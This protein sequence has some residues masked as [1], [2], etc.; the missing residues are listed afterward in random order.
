MADMELYQCIL[1][2]KSACVIKDKEAIL[3][4]RKEKK[5]AWCKLLKN[6][7]KWKLTSESLNVPNMLSV[8]KFRYFRLFFVN[9]IIMCLLT[10]NT[11]KMM[12]TKALFQLVRN[13]QVSSYRA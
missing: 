7:V 4:L 8:F 3:V 1:T 2:E 13:E 5:G 10:L 11:G 9:R 12:K 6:K